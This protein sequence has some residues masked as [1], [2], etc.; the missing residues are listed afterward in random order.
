MK[1]FHEN[2]YIKCISKRYKI[3]TANFICKQP[4]FLFKAFAECV[5]CLMPMF[6]IVE[7]IQGNVTS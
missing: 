7:Y 6:G 3:S 2:K 4:V 5:N 1:F